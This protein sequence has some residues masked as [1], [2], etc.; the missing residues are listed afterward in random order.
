MNPNL[1][2][3]IDVSGLSIHYGNRCAVRDV[4]LTIPA[5]QITAIVGPSGCGKTSFLQTLNRLSDLIPDCRVEGTVRLDGLPTTGPD[6]DV[7]NL[8]RRVG[9][10]FQKPNPFPQSIRCNFEIP[11]REIG[12]SRRDIPALM[13]RSLREVRLWTEVSDRLDQNATRLSG[14][15]QQRLCI[16]RALALYPG[17]ILFD[18]PCSALDPLAAATV[19]SHIRALRG[20]VTI[21]IVTH[22]LAQARRLA[23]HVAV[24]WLRD[25]AGYL[26]ESGPADTLFQNPANPIA[27]NYLSGAAG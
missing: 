15:Q 7:Q 10:V 4:T 21:V 25:G 9:M 27:K 26:A 1:P 13:E 2:P 8:R 6:V 3:A 17:V 19:E 24:F 12:L 18:E 20:R 14:G 23:D 5:G 16:A 22:H 11:L